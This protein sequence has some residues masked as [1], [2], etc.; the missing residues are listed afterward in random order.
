MARFDYT[1]YDSMGAKIS[2]DMEAESEEQVKN[3]LM[4]NGYLPVEIKSQTSI[5]NRGSAHRK[6]PIS[7]LEFF[8]SQLA[9][10]IGNGLRLDKALQLLVKTSTSDNLKA[11]CSYLLTEIRN[12]K[13]LA[14]AIKEL[15][16]FDPVFVTLIAVGETAGNLDEVLVA[17]TK[18]LKFRKELSA[19]VKQAMAY[20][21]MI[22]VVCVLAIVFIFNIVV[23]RMVPLFETAQEL[24]WY[25][26]LLLDATNFFNNYQWFLFGGIVA[27]VFALKSGVSS[28]PQV[29]RRV[30]SSLLKIPFLYKAFATV[31]RIK[32]CESMSMTMQNGLPL[33]QAMKLSQGTLKVARFVKEAESA[34]EDTKQ[35]KSVTDAIG[36][37]SFLDDTYLGLIQV[38]EE[39]GNLDGIFQEVAERSRQEF[40]IWVARFTTLL[41]P[42]MIVLMA[43][44]VGSVVVIMLMSIVSVQDIS[45]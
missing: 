41:E 2:A 33:E 39:S 35:G 34:R 28:S 16:T 8:T 27:V 15:D 38:G 25:T 18:S 4:K 30:E 37:C 29:A 44:L 6:L 1:A 17:L 43:G 45:F 31:E 11:L 19:K 32:Y 20:P 3:H 13:S 23:P 26:V 42:L 5:K 12:G 21:A 10:L 22:L 9:L 14:A 36:K 24:P 7:D 40:E